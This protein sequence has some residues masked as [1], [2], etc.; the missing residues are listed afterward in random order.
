MKRVG[1]NGKLYRGT[2][3]STA[4]TEVLNCVDL[5]LSLSKAMADITTR[6][7]GGWRQK[8]ST[9]KECELEWKM[10]VDP[11]DADYAAIIAAWHSGTPLA[12]K[13]SPTG[14]GGLDG[15]FEITDISEEQ[16]LEDAMA[17]TV[18]AEPT[19]IGG[20]NGRNPTWTAPTEP[21]TVTPGN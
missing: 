17:V 3:G 13:V 7:S 10:Y 16:P 15:D 21:T 20:T 14:N 12:L 1:L 19:N 6:G 18:K 2:A 9:V 11:E 4:A 5:T 8:L